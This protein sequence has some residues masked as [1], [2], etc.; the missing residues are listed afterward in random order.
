[1]RLSLTRPLV[2]IDL[3]TT[4]TN[5]QLDRIVQLAVI[6]L[7]ADGSRR[8]KVRLINPGVPIPASATAVHGITDEAV[9]DA[10]TFKEVARGLAALLE[11]A[12]IGGYN[13][14]RFDWSMLCAEFRR[15][16]VTIEEQRRF[17]DAQ[18]IFF[19]KHPRTLAAAAKVYCD[20]DFTAAH[21]ALADI[22]MTERVL[23]AQLDTHAELPGTVDE[24]DALLFP[25]DPS[26]IDKSGKF[27]WRDGEA[28]VAFGRHAGRPM[29]EVDVG[30]YGWMLSA[31]FPADTK[32][33]AAAAIEGR[34]PERPSA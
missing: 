29:R 17:V 8:D 4:G 6:A 22:R 10:P 2:L 15:A 9:M 7:G 34:Y 19:L 16:G 26:V 12:D 14:R 1:M 28:T 27:R 32:A 23:A 11:G 5:A 13:V 31:D 21:D 24:L 3:E 30:F 20:E 33:I 25:E 18:A